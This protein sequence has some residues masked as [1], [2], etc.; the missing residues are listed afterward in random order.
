[1]TAMAANPAK[2]EAPGLTNRQRFLDACHCR[3]VD[4]PPVWLMRQAGR[5]LPE[6]RKLKSQYPF[7]TLVR[8]PELAAEVTLQPVQRFDFDAAIL[9]S[10]ILVVAEGL[11]QGYKF[12]DGGGI[13]MNFALRTAD[14]IQRLDVPALP[15]R[16]AYIP[17]ALQLVK[18]S[19]GD[20]TALIGFAGSPWTLANFMLEGGSADEFT[21]AG[22]LF[23]SEPELFSR[24]MTKLTA[25]VTRLLQMQIQAG[26]DAVQIFDMVKKYNVAGPRYTSYP[27]ATKFTDAVTWE[28]LSEK[29]EDNNRAPRDL[30]VYFHIPF[31]ETLCWFCGCTTVITLNHSQGMAYVEALG[32]EVAKMAPM[33]NPR[34]ARPFNSISAAA[35]RRFCGRTKSA[36]S[37][38]S[39][40]N[41]SRF[42]RT[43]KRAWRL[44]RAGSRASTW[45]RCAKSASTAPRWACRI[46]IRRCRRRFT[47]S[48]R[49]K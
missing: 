49:A 37:A 7:L 25:A 19:L 33:L 28:Q 16:L 47:A 20:R 3:V 10:D 32:R 9:F 22:K 29:I 42:R 13:E 45:W 39:S 5:A 1:M 27:P 6:Y 23:Y 44:I 46:S 17:R 2:S 34:N 26:V 35:R 4:R 12:R 31:C 8:T 24:L 40:T 11:G 14:D 41:I 30:S 43:S 36:G 15:E 48:S 18:S 38:K 21:R